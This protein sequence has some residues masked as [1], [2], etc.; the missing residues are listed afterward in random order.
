M[1][2]YGLFHLLSS[3]LSVVES[4]ETWCGKG[5]RK[6]APVIEPGGRYPIPKASDTPLL[7][8]SCSPASKPYIHGRDG[9]GTML[10][11]LAVV[12]RNV[13]QAEAIPR[14]YP[15]DTRFS[16][17]VEAEGRR[18]GGGILALGSDQRI[19]FPLTLAPRRTPHQVVCSATA[20]IYHRTFHATTQ[21][22]VL[23]VNPYGGRTVKTDMQTGVLQVQKSG[24][25]EPIIPYGFYNSF[26]GYLAT[27]FSVMDDAV[28]RG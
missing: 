5:Y 9:W 12:Y 23:P 19:R 27:N 25:W 6:D 3:L 15:D 4:Q 17:F 20:L 10:V 14:A 28:A 2:L 1:L 13:A 26:D 8:F 16:V 24:L 22:H 21:L 7:R 11:D 18:L